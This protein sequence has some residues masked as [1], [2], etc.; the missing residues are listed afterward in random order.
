MTIINVTSLQNPT[1][2]EFQQA[3]R[4]LVKMESDFINFNISG[5]HFKLAKQTITSN[6]CS[7]F[8]DLFEYTKNPSSTKLPSGVYY[9]DGEFFAQRSPHLFHIV[10]QNCL[11]G[12]LHIPPSTCKEVITNEIQ[13]WK[14]DFKHLCDCCQAEWNVDDE[15]EETVK[16]NVFPK[17]KYGKFK[18]KMWGILE[19][20]DSSA[21]TTVCFR[22]INK[23]KSILYDNDD[24]V[25]YDFNLLYI[26]GFRFFL[27]IL[28]RALDGEFN[29]VKHPGF[30]VLP[31]KW[32]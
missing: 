5:S 13:F 26:S 4:T 20:E 9:F 19:N 21:L 15:N 6:R 7:F 17:S 23:N 16:K 31:A 29:C 32:N 27:F 24:T 12:K 25:A 2:F 28:Y 1:L 8:D 3:R 30:T 10:L 14:L 22:F 18:H 11:T